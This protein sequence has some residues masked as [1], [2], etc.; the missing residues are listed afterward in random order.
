MTQKKEIKMIEQT[1]DTRTLSEL[2]AAALAKGADPAALDAIE[3]P[4][5]E[6]LAAGDA[7]EA[8]KADAVAVED[9][10]AALARRLEEQQQ[11]LAAAQHRAQP[12]QDEAARIIAP[13][14]RAVS[15]TKAALALIPERRTRAREALEV[16]REREAR[17]LAAGR[18]AR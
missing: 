10:A 6:L 5:R 17:L 18:A 12:H 1:T 9:E 15:D 4:L 14:T 8:A 13:Y 2:R 11:D 3:R 16:A 7:L